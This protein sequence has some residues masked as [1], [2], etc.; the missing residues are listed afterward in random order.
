MC[1]PSTG[2]TGGGEADLR[3]KRLFGGKRSAVV[4]RFRVAG[5]PIIATTFLKKRYLDEYRWRDVKSLCQGSNLSD[6]QLTFPIQ[7]FGDN[8]LRT[9]LG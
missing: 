8:T 9:D 5:K 1:Y 6:V 2:L 4:G 3:C 7:D